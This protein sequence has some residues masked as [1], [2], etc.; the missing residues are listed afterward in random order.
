GQTLDG[1]Y[2]IKAILD[3]AP[4][5]QFLH[6]NRDVS[7]P[8]GG[9]L[10]TRLRVSDD[11]GL[12]AVKFFLGPEGQPRPTAHAF[13]DVRDKKKKDLQRTIDIGGQYRDGDVLIYYAVATDGRNLGPLGGPQTTESARF[14][15]LVQ[16]AAKVAAEKAKRYDQLRAK[17][18][19]I[20]RAQETQRVD[21][22]IAAKKLPDLVQVR[23]AA[24]RIVAG[25]QAIKTDILDVVD[26]FP[27]EPE[28]MTIQQALALLGN[29]EAAMA[30]T[31]ARVVAGLARMAGRTEACTALA[32]TQDK[33]IQSIQTLLAIL[34]SLYKAEK[35][36]TSAAGDDMPPEAREKLSALKASLEQFIEDQRKIIEA[37]ERL[38]KRPVDNFTTED[39]KLLKD[40][41]L[42]QDK[43][44]KFLN[45][46]FADFSKMAQQDFSKPSMLKEL[47]SVKTDVT[48]A[49]DALKKKAT[50][51]ATAIEDNGI[52]NAKTLTANI[53]KWL[54]H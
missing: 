15:I 49:K 38:T 22:E 2:L 11:Y 4:K 3:T 35:A 50:E 45:E 23:S 17:L 47:I 5:V 40:L 41:E 7:V 46:K 54:Q 51:I 34:P 9:K 33:I 26:H 1:L 6:P 16:D 8:I 24:K 27:F 36:K 20:L 53:E 37:S 28:M 31:Q 18:L 19:A 10:D 43:W 13:G 42:A 32:G 44:E 52:E 21:T 30:I 39:E 29:N 12:A 14:K 25:Q 48:M